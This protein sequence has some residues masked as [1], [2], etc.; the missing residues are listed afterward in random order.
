MIERIIDFLKEP[1]NRLGVTAVIINWLCFMYFTA[2]GIVLHDVIYL[3]MGV[4]EVFLTL[5]NIL[6]MRK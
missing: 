1:T 6:T 4:T 2:K 3:L 5:A